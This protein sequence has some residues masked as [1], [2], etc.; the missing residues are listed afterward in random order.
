MHFCVSCL[1]KFPGALI[2]FNKTEKVSSAFDRTLKSF[3]IK[4]SNKFDVLSDQVKQIAMNKQ[5][6]TIESQLIKS[7]KNH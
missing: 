5:F 6:E 2:T 1:Y 3:E 4:L 7:N